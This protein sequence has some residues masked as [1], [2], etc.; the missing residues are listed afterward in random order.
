MHQE[1]AHFHYLRGEWS[2]HGLWGSQQSVFFTKSSSFIQPEVSLPPGSSPWLLQSSQALSLSYP[3]GLLWHWLYLSLSAQDRLLAFLLISLR[4]AA[5][6]N[7]SV[8]LNGI[9]MSLVPTQRWPGEPER[10]R[11]SDSLCDTGQ[12]L[13]LPGSILTCDSAS[14]GCGCKG[15]QDRKKLAD[16]L[17][18]LR[19]PHFTQGFIIKNKNLQ[20]PSEVSREGLWV[21]FEGWNNWGSEQLHLGRTG[22]STLEE[23][24]KEQGLKH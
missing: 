21:P 23:R 1:Q 15:V 3:H 22:R 4:W 12:L 17:I 24:E 19:F 16:V 10:A 5:C 9:F 7:Q 20:Q 2:Q 11:Q 13:N 8:N 18:I 14:M 6:P